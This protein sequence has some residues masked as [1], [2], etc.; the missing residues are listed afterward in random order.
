MI[1]KSLFRNGYNRL[2]NS[3]GKLLV[4]RSYSLIHK[5]ELLYKPLKTGDSFS[6]LY[7]LD[8]A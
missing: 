3:T 6:R 7:P 4:V 2:T 8:L 1:I 5:E